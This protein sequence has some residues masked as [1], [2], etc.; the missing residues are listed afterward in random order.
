MFADTMFVGQDQSSKQTKVSECLVE[1]F[2]RNLKTVELNS[3][4][5]FQ[6][7]GTQ[8]KAVQGAHTKYKIRIVC[9]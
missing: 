8:T 1:I 3:S 9:M 4:K 5:Y 6:L 7:Y 2:L